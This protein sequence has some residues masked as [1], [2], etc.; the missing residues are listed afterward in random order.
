MLA[1]LFVPGGL[2]VALT[3][4]LSF[5]ARSLAR[6]STAPPWVRFLPW[7]VAACGLCGA[8]A[9][10][11]GLLASL[12][13]ITGESVDPSQKAAILANG[14]AESMSSGALSVMILAGFGILLVVLTW[15]TRTPR[16]GS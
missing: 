6:R 16:S 14:I 10:S 15:T 9:T 11:V 5:W 1:I 7:V 2:V 8:L 4:A 13:A 12:G 3:L